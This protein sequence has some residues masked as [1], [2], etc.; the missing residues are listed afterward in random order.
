M[1]SVIVF[2]EL[3][4]TA[5][6]VPLR[7][8]KLEHREAGGSPIS[9]L[10]IPVSKEAC[11]RAVLASLRC[12]DG[13]RLKD[14]GGGE[15]VQSHVSDLLSE[16]GFEEGLVASGPE[17]GGQVVGC[18]MGRVGV[19]LVIKHALVLRVTE[20]SP[21]SLV[22]RAVSASASGEAGPI[23]VTGAIV[24][25]ASEQW[26]FA[27]VIG[28][29]RRVDFPMFYVP[30]CISSDGVSVQMNDDDS[31]WLSGSGNAGKGHGIHGLLP[32]AAMVDLEEWCRLQGSHEL[33]SS[34]DFD[35][36]GGSPISLLE[37]PVSKE[38][39]F[40]AV[41]ASLR[42]ID[43]GRLKDFGGG[44]AVQSHVS[45]LLSEKGFEEGLVASGPEVGGQVVGCSMGRV[46]V[47][48]G[49]HGIGVEG[50]ETDK[51]IDFG[52]GGLTNGA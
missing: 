7:L 29:D 24:V 46:G 38:A 21:L 8:A 12:I 18:S 26:L 28:G 23:G 51:I 34:D 37:I 2:P 20:W 11:F 5:C 13:G 25:G 31:K 50:L 41:L 39:C 27:S 52:G 45:D 30:P 4:I 35:K 48:L 32:T 6:E 40:R 43:G 10:E 36:A 33:S 3:Q 16:K 1:W 42:C 19:G 14:F 47:G 17:V 15:A 9:L 44:E 49:D 22:S